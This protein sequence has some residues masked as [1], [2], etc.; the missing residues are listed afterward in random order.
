MV[1]S[2]A[3]RTRGFT[4]VELLIVIV[5]IAILASITVVAYTAITDKATNT[6]TTVALETWIKALTLYKTDI[7][8]WYGS[9]S[10]LGEGYLYGPTGADTTGIAQCRQDA[11]GTGILENTAFKSAMTKYVGA[12]SRVNPSFVTS[13]SSDTVWRRGLTYYF[14]GGDGTQVYIIA[15]Y[16]GITTCPEVL[17]FTGSAT[18]YDNLI[19]IYLIGHISDT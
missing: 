12:P 5:V 8:H 4:I 10:C 9:S 14:G 19:C 3:L 15:N 6:K 13:R 7:G 1:T 11:A 16:T 17:G 2:H 18:T